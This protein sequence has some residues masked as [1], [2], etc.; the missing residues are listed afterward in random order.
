MLVRSVDISDRTGFVGAVNAV[1]ANAKSVLEGILNSA[2]TLSWTET[3]G[4]A[5]SISVTYGVEG[6]EFQTTG[7]MLEKKFQF[8]LVAASPTIS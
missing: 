4:S 8:S 6:G 3:G 5:H 1:I 7:N 2:T